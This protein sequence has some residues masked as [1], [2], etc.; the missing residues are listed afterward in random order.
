MTTTE[1]NTHR[2][3]P[4]APS[5]QGGPRWWWDELPNE[6]DGLPE[7]IARKLVAAGITSADQVRS[8][9]P[10]KL[11]EVDGIGNVAFA[12]IKQWLRDLDTGGSDGAASHQD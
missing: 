3:P 12:D 5:H 7:H 11:R 2:A 9:G 4:T 6:L 10:G 8:A 1:T